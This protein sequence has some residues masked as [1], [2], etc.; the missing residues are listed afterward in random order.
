MTQL[1]LNER[2]QIRQWNK[3]DYASI[4]ALDQELQSY[5]RTL[6]PS[7]S[8]DPQRSAKHVRELEKVLAEEQDAGA[9]FVAQVDGVVVGYLSCFF[10]EDELEQEPDELRIHDLVVSEQWRRHGIARLLIES[11]EQ[12]ARQHEVKCINVTTLLN[13]EAAKLTYEASGF[14][15]V[16]IVFEKVVRDE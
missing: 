6:R 1:N 11:A 2:I 13:N 3:R 7:R 16:M 4:I 12:L 14:Q 9:L 10:D 5:E 8:T 15:P